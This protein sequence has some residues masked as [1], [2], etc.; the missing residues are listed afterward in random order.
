MFTD[1]DAMSAINR[2]DG[3]RATLAFLG[4]LTSAA[5]YSLRAHPRVLVLGA[6]AGA[7]VLQAL[8]HEAAAVDAVELNP[9]VI[10]LVEQQF[11]AFSGK[12]YTAPGVR[13]HIAEARRFIASGTG[14]YD[15]V[16][17][18]LLDAFGATA[19]GLHALSESYLYTVEALDDYLARLDAG[20]APRDNTLGHAA[21][22]RHA[23]ARRHGGRRARARR[24]RATRS[25]ARADP[26]LA[27]R[28]AARPQRRLH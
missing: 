22:S 2:F 28:H 27:H 16:A 26:R 25:A 6:G 14:S 17:V 18:A 24:R 12:P 19:A 4:D 20:R 1:G 11:A 15:L 7:D 5:P 3:R 8:Y 13:I 10:A 21:A 23:E 9:Q